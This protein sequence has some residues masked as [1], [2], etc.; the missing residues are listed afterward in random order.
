MPELLKH[1]NRLKMPVS[2]TDA[3]VWNLYTDLQNTYKWPQQ[4]KKYFEQLYI[5]YYDNHCD[6]HHKLAHFI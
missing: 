1:Q 3:Q 4:D 5:L 6:A 2:N